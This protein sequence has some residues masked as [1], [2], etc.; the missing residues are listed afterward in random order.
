[1]KLPDFENYMHSESKNYGLNSLRFFDAH[2]NEFWF[3]YSTLVAFKTV[4]PGTKVVR[5]NEWGPTTGKHLNAIDEGRKKHRVNE[6][7]FNRLY[8]EAFGRDCEEGQCTI[9]GHPINQPHS[10][11]KS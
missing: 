5:E 9:D 2:G 1:M 11:R 3:S 4:K 6:E 8:A 7:T 10:E